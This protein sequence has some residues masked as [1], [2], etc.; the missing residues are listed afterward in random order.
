[1]EV[2]L[3][4]WQ[5]QLASARHD[6]A[7]QLEAEIKQGV[8]DLLY[9]ENCSSSLSKVNSAVKEIKQLNFIPAT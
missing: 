8:Q 4:V 2:N 1:M 7:Q 9:M 6:L 3:V 5:E